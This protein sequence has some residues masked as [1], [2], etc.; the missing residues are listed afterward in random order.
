M[1]NMVILIIAAVLSCIVVAAQAP[2][3]KETGKEMK[4][5]IKPGK[6]ESKAKLNK[7]SGIVESIDLAAGKLTIND[8]KKMTMTMTI[9]AE[10]KIMKAGKPVSLSA[11]MAGDKVHIMYEGDMASP[12]VKEVKVIEK[13]GPKKEKAEKKAGGKP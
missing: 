9:G 5:E 3:P 2:V 6:K 12:A 1:K 4:S 10:A 13:A 8:Q 11:I 7:C